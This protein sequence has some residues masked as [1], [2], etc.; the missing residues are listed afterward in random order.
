MWKQITDGTEAKSKTDNRVVGASK[1]KGDGVEKKKND[2]K[3][4]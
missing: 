3:S 2:G 4:H 1:N